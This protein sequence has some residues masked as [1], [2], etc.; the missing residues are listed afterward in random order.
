MGPALIHQGLDGCNSRDCRGAQSRWD[1]RR[2]EA[3]FGLDGG[4]G[5]LAYSVKGHTPSTGKVGEGGACR[6]GVI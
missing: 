3:V 1:V 4:L 2:A 5:G 6:R